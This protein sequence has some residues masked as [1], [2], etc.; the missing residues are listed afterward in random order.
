MKSKAKK[1]VLA[2]TIS[3]GLFVVIS[4]LNISFASNKLPGNKRVNGQQLF[5]GENIAVAQTA[6]GK[7]RGFILRDI[8]NFRGIPYGANTAGENRFM[9]PLKPKSWTDI[10]PAVFFG[11]SAPQTIYDRSAESYS[12]F[13]DHWNYDEISEDCLRLNIWTP[14]LADGKKRPVLVWLHGGGFSRGNGMEQD[15]YDGENISRYGDIVFCS[16]NHRLGSLGFTDLSSVGK[17]KFKDSGNVGML[18]IIEALKWVKQ[19]ISNFGGDPENVTIMG[20]S[21]GGSKVSIIASMPAAKGLI[22]KGVALSG[23]SIRGND[24][25]YSQ[26]LGAYVLKEAGL[27]AS[28]LDSLQR[29]SWSDYLSVSER[30][31][32]TFNKENQGTKIQRGGFSPVAD[33]TNIPESEF[34]AAN[35]SSLPNIPM[36][37]SSTFQEWNPDRDDPSFE[38][39]TLP[40]VTQKLRNVY[41]E[42]AEKIVNAYAKQFPECRPIEIWALIVSNRKGIISTAKAK[43]HQKTPVYMA[44]FG[45]QSPLFDGRHRAFHCLDI[46][47]WF[48]NTDRMLTHTGGGDKPKALSNKMADALIQFMYTGNP[49]CKSLPKWPEYTEEKGKVMILN[50]AC[51]VKDDPDKAARV[52][53]P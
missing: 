40:E 19:N 47:F 26:K 7:V 1:I 4:S 28:Q 51:T 44:W 34:Y 39:L 20:Q 35:D 30:A 29:M 53:I 22:N 25:A 52:F 27:D 5:I 14:A 48:L 31:E 6:Y 3:L 24:K 37:L 12:A 21:G 42:N 10:R 13:V 2:K 16:I 36:I 41:G 50:D 38:N 43:L 11:N 15:G 17:S 33:G 45:W 32:A 46:S 23:S 18:D 9:P 49:N 8:F